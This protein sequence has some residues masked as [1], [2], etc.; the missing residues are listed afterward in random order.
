M[1]LTDTPS[2]IRIC[3]FSLLSSLFFHFPFGPS[4]GTITLHPFYMLKSI[5]RV[6]KGFELLHQILTRALAASLKSIF[7]YR[8]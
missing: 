7:T 2:Y 8:A 6:S 4:F 1:L 3:D 5:G